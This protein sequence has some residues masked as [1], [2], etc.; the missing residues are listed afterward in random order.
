MGSEQLFNF[1]RICKIIKRR[2]Y[3]LRWS[4]SQYFD[5]TTFQNRSVLEFWLLRRRR[6]LTIWNSEILKESDPDLRKTSSDQNRNRFSRNRIL[7]TK[8]IWE[9]TQNI[10]KEELQICLSREKRT[11]QLRSGLCQKF[12][13]SILK[14][15]Q[16][17]Y[18]SWHHVLGEHLTCRPE[19]FLGE[20]RKQF[21]HRS[22]CWLKHSG[23][24]NQNF[25]RFPGRNCILILAWPEFLEVI[26]ESAKDWPSSA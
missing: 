15:N 16:I 20:K 10:L 23:I 13:G 19:S 2:K 17:Q 21:W 26:W 1:R 22:G 18:S 12:S 25:R 8:L 9:K 14:K 7:E 6:V 3:I 5:Q 24:L 11:P 4:D